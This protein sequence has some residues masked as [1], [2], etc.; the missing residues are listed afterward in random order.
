MFVIK[1]IIEAFVLPPGCFVAALGGLAFYLRR[2]SR[3]GAAAC[4]ALAVLTWAGSTR[5]FSDALLR[6][7]EYAY[8]V[9]ARPSGDAIVMLCG[10]SRGLPAVFSAAENLSPSTLERAV[11]AALLHKKTGLPV[12]VTGGSPFSEKPEAE[13]AAACLYELGVPRAAVITET[14]A[15][16]TRENSLNARAICAEKGYKKIILLTLAY[17]MPRAVFLFKEAGFDGVVP[18]PVGRR[19]VPGAK[20]FFRDYLPGAQADTGAALNEIFGLVFYRTRALLTEPFKKGR[21][22]K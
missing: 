9:P 6:P 5:I 17:H 19:T 21:I 7:L 11:A 3:A 12:I 2:R 18:F 20:R 16:D 1:K 4:A 14:L 15:R 13:A 10:G 22:S 8:S